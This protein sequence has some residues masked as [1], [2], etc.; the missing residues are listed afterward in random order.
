V[1][2]KAVL[3]EMHAAGAAIQRVDNCWLAFERVA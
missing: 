3:D 1:D 2:V